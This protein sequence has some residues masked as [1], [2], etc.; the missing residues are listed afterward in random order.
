MTA[1]SHIF[2]PF[3]VDI[4]R[5]FSLYKV[6]QLL[7]KKSHKALQQILVSIETFENDFAAAFDVVDEYLESHG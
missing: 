1:S 3:A 5:I 7:S 6:R 2:L 4:G